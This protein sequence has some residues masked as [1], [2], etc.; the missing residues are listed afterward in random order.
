MFTLQ[1]AVLWHSCFTVN[2]L[3]STICRSLKYNKLKLRFEVSIRLTKKLENKL[4]KLIK[5]RKT[6]SKR[7][8]K[9]TSQQPAPR[10]RPTGPRQAPTDSSHTVASHSPYKRGDFELKN[11]KT[12]RDKTVHIKKTKLNQNYLTLSRTNFRSSHS[13]NKRLAYSSMNTA[14]GPGLESHRRCWLLA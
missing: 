8:K 9:L 10:S 1:K 2:G 11:Y 4:K 13:P 7:S 3:G 14:N 12:C 5:F 6:G